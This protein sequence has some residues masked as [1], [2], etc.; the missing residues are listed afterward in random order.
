MRA[1]AWLVALI[2]LPQILALPAA[3]EQ[4]SGDVI[5]V[6]IVCHDLE[7]LQVTWNPDPLAGQNLSLDFRYGD[8]VL[9]SCP[10]YFLLGGF[11]SGCIFPSR[12]GLLEVTLR[13]GGG[14]TVF[15]RRR[16]ASAWLKPRPPW[17]VTFLWTPEAVT[18]SCPAHSYPGLDYEVQHRDPFVEDWQTTSEP[19]CN[20]TV[21]GLD[22]GRCYDFRVR[23]A[24][25]DFYYGLEAQPSEWTSVIHWRGAAPAASCDTGHDSPPTSPLPLACGL[26]TLLTLAMLLAMLW[27]RRVKDALL[28][29]VPDPSGSFP[30]LFE[31][32]H[33]NFQAWISDSQATA[34][35]KPEEGHD[36]ILPR[37]KWAE[38]EDHPAPGE[39]GSRALVS[40]G[41]ATFR[42][43][44]SGYMTL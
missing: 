21:G 33:G 11:T 36:I 2:L 22:P 4:S 44:G 14:A 5:P 35:G 15:S 1:A 40:M 32:H 7:S 10:R 26:A 43:D 39:L 34:L 23:A 6:S 38:P 3:Q 12:A 24:P 17:N 27:L 28:P 8:H 25:Q 31:K 16:P 30:G 9:R 41:G 19:Q 42:L 20:V 29:C 37:G 18:V 13:D